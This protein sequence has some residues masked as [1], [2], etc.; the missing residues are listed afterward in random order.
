MAQTSP[1]D[2][3]VDVAS[4]ADFEEL[5][6]VLLVAARANDVEVEGTYNAWSKEGENLQVDIAEVVD[7]SQQ[8]APGPFDGSAGDARTSGAATSRVSLVQV[9][10]GLPLDD[11]EG[12]AFC[13]ECLDGITEGDIV[14]VYCR[15]PVDGHR[16]DVHQAYC[17][18]CGVT[19]LRSP[20]YGQT[21]V[22]VEATVAEA[23]DSSDQSSRQVLNN[24]R[25]FD[26]SGPSDGAI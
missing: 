4:R 3:D 6:S 5:L 7:G 18:D 9:L 16:W 25:L 20:S 2:V 10:T 1:V 22:L 19:T 11:Q 21:G 15:K 14:T 8:R 24:V 17:R 12:T 23:M 26:Y 13:R